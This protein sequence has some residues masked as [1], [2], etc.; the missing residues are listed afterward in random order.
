[1]FKMD[2]ND[3][4]PSLDALMSPNLAGEPYLKKLPLDPWGHAYQ[5]EIAQGQAH[6]FTVSPKGV[7]CDNLQN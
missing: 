4:P 6:I 3:Y 7:Q 2:Q 1:M 5:Y